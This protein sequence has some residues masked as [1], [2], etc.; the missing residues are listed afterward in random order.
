MPEEIQKWF[1]QTL[2]VK[3]LK[4]IISSLNKKEEQIVFQNSIKIIQK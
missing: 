3:S 2:K 4:I 1:D